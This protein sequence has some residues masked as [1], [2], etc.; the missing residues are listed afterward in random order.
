MGLKDFFKRKKTT[1]DP[2]PISDLILANLKK[3]Y[4]VDYNLKTWEVISAGRYDWGQN[5]ITYEWQL[6][7]H[8]ETIFLEREI[9]DEDLWCITKKMPFQQLDIQTIN[10]IKEF[11]KPP[12]TI[13]FKEKQYYLDETG[14]ALFYKNNSDLGK[15]VFK[16]DYAD[17]KTGTFYLTIEQW[18]ENDYELS[19]GEKVEEYQFSNILPSQ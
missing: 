2:D 5:D 3:G 10:K 17:D 8:D 6:S 14:G 1:V 4:Y 7:S 13:F 12:D 11:S 18:G 9:D 19:I 15:E 16:W